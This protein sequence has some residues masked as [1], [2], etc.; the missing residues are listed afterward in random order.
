M[1]HSRDL[2]A[3][4]LEP[5]LLLRHNLVRFLVPGDLLHAA[6]AVDDVE[7]WWQSEWRLEIVRDRP[8][9]L[10]S[11]LRDVLDLGV[12]GARRPEGVEP[13]GEA[14]LRRVLLQIFCMSYCQAPLPKQAGGI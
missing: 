11:D 3:R 10:Q 4:E 5:Q 1:H 2:R 14:H 13:R 8:D 9:R 6:A 12:P 7:D